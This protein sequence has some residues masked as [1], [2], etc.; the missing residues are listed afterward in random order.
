MRQRV[1]RLD[2]LRSPLI[3]LTVDLVLLLLQSLVLSLD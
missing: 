2:V 1:L 3:S